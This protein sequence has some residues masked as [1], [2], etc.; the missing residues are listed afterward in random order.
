MPSTRSPVSPATPVSPGAQGRRRSRWGALV[1]ATAAVRST[2]PATVESALK[3]LG[4]RRRWLAPLVYAAGTVAVVFD[5]V[6]LL[7]RNWRLTLLQLFP[8]AWISVMTWNMKNHLL[9]RPS[10]S[11]SAV[12]PIAV[13]VLLGAQIAYWCNATFAYT[14][15]QSPTADIRAAFGEARPHWRLVGGLAALTGA[16]QAAIWLA[17]PRLQADWHWL[18]LVV[19]FVVQV[20]LFIAIPCWLLGVRKTGNAD[21][22]GE[23]AEGAEKASQAASG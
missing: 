23:D 22:L 3:D 13:G 12:I 17:M 19:M 15:T 14:M 2:D 4:G 16:L 6:L 21:G 20:Y 10:F 5:G 8:A 1:S 11:T 7:L 9:S 18:A